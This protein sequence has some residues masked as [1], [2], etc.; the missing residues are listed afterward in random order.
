MLFRLVQVLALVSISV[1]TASLVRRQIPDGLSCSLLQLSVQLA[2]VPDTEMN[3]CRSTIT[4]F[5][6]IPTDEYVERQ[7]EVLTAL[8]RICNEECLPHVL[9]LVDICYPSFRETLRLACATTTT[10]AVE[11]STTIGTTNT[12]DATNMDATSTIDA[13]NTVDTTNTID[14]INTMD[15]TN[16]TTSADALQGGAP[17]QLGSVAVVM[18]IVW[19]SS[20]LKL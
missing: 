19:V 8:Q 11:A 1:C 13:T 6:Q 3:P 4:N 9:N 20:F 16:A 5:V 2:T 17:R 12:I 18:L 7:D 14:P 15:S 10:A